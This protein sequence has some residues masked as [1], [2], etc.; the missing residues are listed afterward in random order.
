MLLQTKSKK[1]AKHFSFLTNRKQFKKKLTPLKFKRFSIKR[2][3][4]LTWWRK[5]SPVTDMEGIICDSSVCAGKTV[6]MS[7]SYVMW[8]METFID[9]N[10]DMVGK[11]SGSF[12]RNVITP[13]KRVLK[14]RGYIVN[15]YCSGNMFSI[16]KNGVT[17]FFYV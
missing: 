8:E 10:L 1:K 9:E 12:R 11:P 15:D 17:N 3:H 4:V 2:K 5:D 7:L 13:L 16:S 6:V 14:A